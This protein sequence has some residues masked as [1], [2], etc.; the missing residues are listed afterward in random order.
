VCG[1]QGA[2][3]ATL[4]TGYLLA[5]DL[6]T[7]NHLF[8][9]DLPRAPCMGWRDDVRFPIG[10]SLLF[11]YYLIFMIARCRRADPLVHREIQC[12]FNNCSASAIF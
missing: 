9:R 2:V 8:V 4:L 12:W 5:A 7:G 1:P 10:I 11:E 6:I 3:P